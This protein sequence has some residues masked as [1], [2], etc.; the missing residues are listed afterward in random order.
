MQPVRAASSVL[1]LSVLALAACATGVID[2]ESPLETRPG[3]GAGDAAP[4][5]EAK[6]QGEQGEGKLDAGLAPA[7]DAGPGKPSDAAA[8]DAAPSFAKDAGSDA[9]VAVA[10]CTT[11]FINEVQVAGGSASD[12]LVELY[13]PGAACSFTGW[14]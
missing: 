14:K 5:P 12:E 1:V 7:R 13:N 11:L 4:S 2:P 9:P 8:P 3:A 10:A 6:T